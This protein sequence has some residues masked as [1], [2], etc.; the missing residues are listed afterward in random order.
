M[1]LTAVR[2]ANK[3]YVALGEDQS[4]AVRYIGGLQIS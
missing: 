1:D 3:N 4:L 2:H